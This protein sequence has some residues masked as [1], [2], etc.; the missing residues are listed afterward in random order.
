[1]PQWD[2]NQLTNSQ[3]I[4]LQCHRRSTSKRREQRSANN[5]NWRKYML[6]YYFSRKDSVFNIE[7]ILIPPAS[8]KEMSK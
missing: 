4:I 7:Y 5:R 3:I 1:M 6:V 2:L 8:Q